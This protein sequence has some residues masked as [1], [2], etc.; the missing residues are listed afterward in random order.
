M[1]ALSGFP[2]V[3]LKDCTVVF[4]CIGVGY[5]TPLT[6]LKTRLALTEDDNP[7]TLLLVTIT[8]Q[9]WNVAVVGSGQRLE[10]RGHISTVLHRLRIIFLCWNLKQCGDGPCIT[11]SLPCLHEVI[12]FVN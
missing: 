2:I 1:C 9:I 8:R 3:L 4:T 11:P 7:Y 5:K 6:Y 10:V 12:D